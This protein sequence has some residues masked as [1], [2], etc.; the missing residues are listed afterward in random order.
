VEESVGIAERSQDSPAHLLSLIRSNEATTRGELVKATGLARSTIAQR[1]DTLISSGFVVEVGGA[2]STGGRPPTLL[3]FNGD[4]GVVLAADMGATHSRIAVSNLAAEPLADTSAEIDIDLGPEA[5]LSWLEE[6]F[7]DLLT[8]ASRSPSDV[9]GIGI[10]LP[11]PVDFDRGMAINPPIMMGWHEYPVADRLQGKYGVP[12]L[13]DNDVNIMAIGEH[14]A[15]Y[16]EVDDLIFVKVGTGIGSGL[17]L[18]GR[19]HRGAH[20]AAGDI[21]HVQAASEDVVCRCG[22]TGC[23]EAA[24]GGAALAVALSEGRER[25]AGSRGVVDLV[26]RSD[27]RALRAV[28]SAGRMI[29][30]VL[31][32]TVNLL[33]PSVIVIGGDM[34]AAEQQLLAGIREVVYRRSTTLSTTDLTITTT[35]LGEGAGITG[36]A[37]MVVDHLLEPRNLEIAMAQARAG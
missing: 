31:A 36:A 24:A 32:S 2:A 27:K 19:I 13:V 34:A 14:F 29:G 37:A 5:V 9:R 1:V 10:G 26:Q 4:A 18:G 25:V 23:L 21:G 17:I 11:G 3:G 16:P 35:S 33:N 12:V 8:K 7:E 20:G 22:N 30:Q 28:R 15:S 6:T